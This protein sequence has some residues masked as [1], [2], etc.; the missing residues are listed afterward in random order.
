[1]GLYLSYRASDY[2]A[3]GTIGFIN[4]IA[5]ILIFVSSVLYLISHKVPNS[6]GEEKRSEKHH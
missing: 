6:Q 3:E 5:H 1:V 4:N 2:G